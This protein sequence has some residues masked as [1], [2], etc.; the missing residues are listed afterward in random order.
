MLVL[1]A[2]FTLLLRGWHAREE[3]FLPNASLAVR[4]SRAVRVMKR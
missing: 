4:H 1:R 3:E 2:G